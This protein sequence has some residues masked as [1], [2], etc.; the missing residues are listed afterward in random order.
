MSTLNNQKVTEISNNFF[1][2]KGINLVSNGNEFRVSK[3]SIT[4]RDTNEGCMLN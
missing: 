3:K 1:K 4:I 2:G